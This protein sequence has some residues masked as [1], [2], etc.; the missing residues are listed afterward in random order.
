MKNRHWLEWLYSKVQ[1]INVSGCKTQKQAD[2]FLQAAA[3]ARIECIDNQ[4]FFEAQ[5]IS[6]NILQGM[7]S[8][9]EVLKLARQAF[10]NHMVKSV[11]VIEEVKLIDGLQFE[12]YEKRLEFRIGWLDSIVKTD[13]VVKSLDMD[14]NERFMKYLSENMNEIA[15]KGVGLNI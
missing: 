13:H 10:V 7:F 15:E 6:D 2:E 5:K 11:H 1:S 14:F 4:N 9:E 12:D 8:S 3:I